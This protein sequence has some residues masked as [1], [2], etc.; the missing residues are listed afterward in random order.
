M[1]AAVGLMALTA[2]ERETLIREAAAAAATSATVDEGLTVQVTGGVIVGHAPADGDTPARLHIRASGFSLR[3]ALQDTA[4]AQRPLDIEVDNTPARGKW[5]YQAWRGALPP[6]LAALRQC[7]GTT[8]QRPTATE[9][10]DWLSLGAPVEFAPGHM[11][12][13]QPIVSAGVSEPMDCAADDPTA[14]VAGAAVGQ[15][16]V[17]RRWCMRLWPAADEARFITDNSQRSDPAQ[18]AVS[19]GAYAT[20]EGGP[21]QSAPF[22]V[23]LSDD[24]L[25]EPTVLG[26]GTNALRFAVMGNSAG[27]RSWRRAVVRSISNH[28]ATDDLR[29]VL[30]TGD[31]AADGSTAE[32][33]AAVED[34]ADLPV[35]WFAT[36]GERDV[37]GAR[38]EDLVER[39][40]PLTDSL[41][42]ATAA[43]R[44]RVS[45]RLVLLDSAD[46][47]LSSHAF[48]SLEGWL[49]DLDAPDVRLVA[50]HV[51][52]FD[53]YGLRN[54]AFKSR[55]EA[56]RLVS[57]LSRGG[58]ENLF[59][60]HLSL[61]AKQDVAGISVWHAGG[62]GAPLESLTNDRHHFLIV[63][64]NSAGAIS[65]E[66]VD[67]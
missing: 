9:H 16:V 65:V 38:P 7:C 31:L 46:G 5:T 22:I 53:L 28:V 58:V 11:T 3:V 37:D 51:A 36:V 50:T 1:V 56:V 2:C 60:S 10:P 54:K 23:V 21:V 44:K 20:P 33:D 26:D 48:R 55:A 52:P 29:F 30:A 15:E 6:D 64:V 35:P 41:D 63:T 49:Q 57:A 18:S 14:A 45:F 66:R 24:F 61:F 67:L 12:A 43:G 40:G 27:V 34:L 47:G 39:F 32:L 19:C 4:C 62:G 42:F 59:T 17:R 8:F 25:P 13:A